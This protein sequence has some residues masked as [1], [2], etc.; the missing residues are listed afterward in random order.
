[1]KGRQATCLHQPRQFPIHQGQVGLGEHCLCQQRSAFRCLT[2]DFEPGL[3][4]QEHLQRMSYPVLVIR[5]QDS[6]G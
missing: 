3:L 1:M 5:N 2:Y 4:R 6:H